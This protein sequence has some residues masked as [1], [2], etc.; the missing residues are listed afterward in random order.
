MKKCREKECMTLNNPGRRYYSITVS[1]PRNVSI[2]ESDVNRRISSLVKLRNALS[3]S[4]SVGQLTIPF[5]QKF[6]SQHKPVKWMQPG[7][8][9]MS[10]TMN[11][12]CL[13]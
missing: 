7:T 3:G 4:L 1:E 12:L 11:T 13:N 10:N 6:E 8:K 2:D 9:K 5:P